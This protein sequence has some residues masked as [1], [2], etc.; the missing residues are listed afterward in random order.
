M[1]TGGFLMAQGSI[2]PESKSQKRHHDS[3]EAP[4]SKEGEEQREAK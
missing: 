3:A 1:S 4:E 2:R